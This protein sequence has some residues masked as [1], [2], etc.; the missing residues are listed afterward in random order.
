M[1]APMPI[2]GPGALNVLVGYFPAARQ[3]DLCS[4][5]VPA[6]PPVDPIM[7]GSPTVL[8]G[9]LPA[10]HMG[11]P[12]T[13]G[14]VILPPCLPTVMIGYAGMPPVVL[15]GGIIMQDVVLPDGSVVTKVGDNITIEGT[16]EFRAKVAA[17]VQKLAGTPTGQGLLESLDSSGKKLTINQGSP[18]QTSYDAPADRFKKAD[19]SAGPG[20]NA[21]ITITGN[22][23]TLEDGSEPWMTTPSEVVLGHEMVHAEQAQRG[24]ITPGETAGVRNRETEAVGLPPYQNNP[25]TENK[26]RRDLGY[27]ARERY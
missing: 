14:G 26:I 4:C 13:L 15:P 17:D 23:E 21:T 24:Q 25:Y 3:T 10:A 6:I 9:G 20:S 8:I 18:P 22:G 12:T 16:P 7:L 2:L 27:P 19:G 5:L 11:A 1:G